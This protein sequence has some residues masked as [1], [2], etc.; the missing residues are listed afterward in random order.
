VARGHGI[1][2]RGSASIRKACGVAY[3]FRRPRSLELVKAV[4][5]WSVAERRPSAELVELPNQRLS[6]GEWEM[7]S[8]RRWS[9]A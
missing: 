8:R 4:R 6:D 2:E 1:S 3:A 7:S 9:C 5:S